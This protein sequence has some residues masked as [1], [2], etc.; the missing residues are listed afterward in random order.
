MLFALILELL[1]GMCYACS[2]TNEKGIG[3]VQAICGAFLKLD[4]SIGYA[5]A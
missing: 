5:I 3:I 1:V 2:V 4:V